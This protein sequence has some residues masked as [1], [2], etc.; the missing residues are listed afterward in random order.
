MSFSHLIDFKKIDPKNFYFIDQLENNQISIDDCS[1]LMILTYEKKDPFAIVNLK[2][3]SIDP[4]K[5]IQVYQNILN[6][7]VNLNIPFDFN[8]D[9]IDSSVFE[10]FVNRWFSDF[11]TIKYVP[12]MIQIVSEAVMYYSYGIYDKTTS[13]CSEDVLK[14]IIEKNLLI[15]EKIKLFL[16]SIPLFFQS[17]IQGFITSHL[18]K[19][20]DFDSK[21]DDEKRIIFTQEVLSK[22]SQSNIEVIDDIDFIPKNVI[23]LFYHQ[24][25]IIDYYSNLDESVPRKFFLQQF[26]SYMYNGLNLYYYFFNENNVIFNT[27]KYIGDSSEH[28]K[29]AIRSLKIKRKEQIVF[30]IRKC[31]YLIKL[32]LYRIKQM[33]YKFYL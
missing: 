9:K 2:N 15:I 14:Q 6:Q 33:F 20:P 4:T 11:R 5:S 3:L 21:K 18:D 26:T 16:D 28:A 7:T 25:F 12:S 17:S 32:R 29:E 24:K 30:F 19:H 1:K 31:F 23:C 13:I 10:N 22:M 27:V 8:F